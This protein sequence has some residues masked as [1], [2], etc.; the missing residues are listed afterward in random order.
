MDMSNKLRVQPDFLVNS[1][2]TTDFL[3]FNVSFLKHLL[4]KWLSVLTSPLHSAWGSHSSALVLS[5]QPAGSVLLCPPTFYQM[6]CSSPRVRWLV[7]KTPWSQS[8]MLLSLCH[9]I[10]CQWNWWYMSMKRRVLF[11]WK[12]SSLFKKDSV[13][14]KC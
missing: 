6:N 3:E 12:L 5:M 14:M 9:L 11:L 10:N 1:G 4:L 8:D 7:P 13:K 2:F